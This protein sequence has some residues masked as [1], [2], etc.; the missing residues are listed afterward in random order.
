VRKIKI[1]GTCIGRCVTRE[2]GVCWGRGVLV[3]LGCVPW[4]WLFIFWKHYLNQVRN[5]PQAEAFCETKVVIYVIISFAE[6]L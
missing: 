2:E 6:I 5:K 4:G 1:R 3:L